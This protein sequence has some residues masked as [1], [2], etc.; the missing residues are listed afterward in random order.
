MH[1]AP[2]A[3]STHKPRVRD[4]YSA[5]TPHIHITHKTIE[6]SINIFFWHNPLDWFEDEKIWKNMGEMTLLLWRLDEICG[7][8]LYILTNNSD[9]NEKGKQ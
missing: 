6:S 2:D 3:N 1:I 5:R 9:T 4:E 8:N 7:C